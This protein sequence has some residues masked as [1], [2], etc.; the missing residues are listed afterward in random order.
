PKGDAAAGEAWQGAAIGML[1]RASPEHLIHHQDAFHSAARDDQTA[2]AHERSPEDAGEDS[3]V[4]E[5]LRPGLDLSHV[6]HVGGV[7]AGAE[8]VHEQLEAPAS[9]HAGTLRDR[10]ASMSRARSR[11]AMVLPSSRATP[12]RNSA[13]P[14]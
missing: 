14:A 13:G 12:E 8:L 3:A 4:A 5:A 11:T 2:R 1:H 7:A 9:A 6:R 10:A